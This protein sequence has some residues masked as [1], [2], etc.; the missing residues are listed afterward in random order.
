MVKSSKPIEETVFKLKLKGSGPEL[1]E[2]PKDP[3]LGVLNPEAMQ[4]QQR[5]TTL[6]K[7]RDEIEESLG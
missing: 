2:A 1:K 6:K 3:S 7:K 5:R 4:D